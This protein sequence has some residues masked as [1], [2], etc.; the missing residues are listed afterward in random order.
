M[1]RKA[2]GVKLFGRHFDRS[3]CRGC[4]GCENILWTNFSHVSQC[5]SHISLDS[6]SSDVKGA[7]TGLRYAAEDSKVF[8]K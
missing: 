4:L 5:C 2:D 7:A 3:L 8:L 1:E 6:S